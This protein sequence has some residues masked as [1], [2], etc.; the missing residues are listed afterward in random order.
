[1][2]VCPSAKILG[3][4]FPIKHRSRRRR[5]RQRG[6]APV[7]PRVARCAAPHR[8]KSPLSPPPGCGGSSLPLT[9]TVTRPASQQPPSRPPRAPSARP[10]PACRQHGDPRRGR[11][12]RPC[13]GGLPR[14]MWPALPPLRVGRRAGELDRI[15]PRLC[16]AAR[17][18]VACAAVADG[19]SRAAD[20]VAFGRR[21]A[22]PPRRGARHPLARAGDCRNVNGGAAGADRGRRVG[23]G[24][25]A[26]GRGGAGGG[27]A[28]SVADG[29]S[30]GSP[31]DARRRRVGRRPVGRAPVAHCG[32]SGRR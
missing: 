12:P 32:D 28:A 6:V 22:R 15:P 7:P 30:R 3:T 26:G 9:P 8:V 31:A 25:R 19:G 16:V 20:V 29:G 27:G 17:G 24:T 23:G 10:P 21:V 4:P 18:G 2:R 5:A 1:V 11:H 14:L 13:V